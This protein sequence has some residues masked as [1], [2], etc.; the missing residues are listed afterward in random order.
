M[1]LLLLACPAPDD[2]GP[3]D[4][5]SPGEVDTD[6]DGEDTGLDTGDPIVWETVLDVGDGHEYAHPN[7]VPWES[8]SPSTLVR[9][10]EGTYAAKWVINTT[11]PLRVEGV[12]SV[13]I[14]GK[15]ATTRTELDYW[16]EARSVLKIGGSSIGPD[17][18][19]DITIA[20][21]TFRGAMQDNGFVNDAGDTETYADNAACIHV[22]AGSGVKLVGNTLTDCG[23]GLFIGNQSGEIEVHGNHLYGNGVVGSAYEHNS[24]TEARGIDFAWNRYGRLREGA[25]GNN[26]KDRSSGL[27][28]RYNWIEGGNRQLDLVESGELDQ[29]DPV[30]VVG[31]VL[32]EGE[33]DG[34]SQIVHYGGDNGN[35][36]RS[37]P[38]VLVH[39]TV[40]STRQGNTTWLRLS[41]PENTA[42]A[43]D[44]VVVANSLAITAG[45]GQVTLVDNALPEGWR[46]T[47]EAEFD[48]S[49]SDEGTLTA[50]PELDENHEPGSASPLLG[51]AG[52]LGELCTDVDLQY[53]QHQQA[54]ERA[55]RS[56]IGA[57]EGP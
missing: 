38:L 30:C 36:Y 33:G 51:A 20:N 34:N 8:L 23:N 22:E 10:H 49:I 53:V 35:V 29:S 5:S 44:N 14:E 57:F 13:I 16:N 17:M 46:T 1:L 24:Y 47:F 9:I 4:D 3:S 31:N 21:L 42:L 37:G 40:V 28:V 2:T 18:A 52:D 11:G 55:A 43:Y 41:T 25:D 48:G 50:A 54:S 7:E 26:L 56:T 27:R 12:G 15:D 32:I 19:S 39:N 6:L 45:A